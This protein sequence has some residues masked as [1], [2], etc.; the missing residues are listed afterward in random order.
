M[1]L[2]DKQQG[3]RRGIMIGAVLTIAGLAAG[4]VYLPTSLTVDASM[5]DRLAYALKADILVIFWLLLCIGKLAGHRF[6][7]PEDIDGSGL[8]A[9][10][11]K[12]KVLQSLLQNTLEQTVLAVTLHLIWAVVMPVTWM[13]GIP[14][15][16]I[17]FF[18]GRIFFIRSY[19]G[20][21]PARALGFSLTFYPSMLMLLIIIA[22]LVLDLV[23]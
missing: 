15:A 16:A 4:I 8:T 13:P 10:T 5:G 6:F 9:G 19:T 1:A 7:T 11:D 21:A 23:K 12:A 2:T 14:A 20:G 22:T 17:L 18:F 3:V